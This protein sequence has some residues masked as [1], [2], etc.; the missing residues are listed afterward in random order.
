MIGSWVLEGMM[1]GQQTTHDVT[2]QWV[3]G[4][5]Y[6]QMHEISRE[7]TRANTPRYEAIVYIGRDSSTKE[8]AALWLDNTAYGA[9]A[10]AGTGHGVAAGDSIAFVFTESPTNHVD[11]R[12]K[13]NRS[14]DTWEWHLDNVESGVAKPFA[15]VTLRRNASA[16]SQEHSPND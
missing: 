5:E 12:F 6:V 1:A 7:R 16:R 14:A 13:Y 15:R 10:P 9:F 3:L 8:Y 2:F 4:Y 11:T